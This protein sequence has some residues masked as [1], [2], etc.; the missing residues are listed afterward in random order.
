MVV[1]AFSETFSTDGFFSRAAVATGTA[2]DFFFAVPAV[3]FATVVVCAGDFGECFAT[4]VF[5]GDFE[6]LELFV[7]FEFL[8]V[9]EL[10]DDASMVCLAL[11]F[12]TID[13]PGKI[14]AP[15]IPFAFMI[16]DV[17]V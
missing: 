6:L 15:F 17:V 14:T 7:L 5:A 2:V 1:S 12:T 9:L 13:W 11:L 8:E 16:A 4:V 10:A 3:F